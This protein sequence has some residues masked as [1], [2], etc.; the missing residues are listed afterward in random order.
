VTPV[1][2]YVWH[3]D[4]HRQTGERLYFVRLYFEPVYPN[5]VAELE[6]R[7]RDLN[8]FSAHVYELVGAYDLVLRI[9]YSGDVRQ[10]ITDLKLPEMRR[11]DFMEVRH[12]HEHWVMS[13]KR[14]SLDATPQI[15]D[16]SPEL[17]EE[18]NRKVNSDES[19][20]LDEYVEA[21]LIAPV[22]AGRGVKFFVSVVASFGT[23]SSIRFDHVL[24]SHVS[25]VLD[26]AS[27]LI[28]ARSVYAGDGFARLLLMGRFEPQDYFRFMERVVAE[29]N[30][31]YMRELFN[32]R[33]FTAFG[34]K[35]GP[36]LGTDAIDL[37]GFRTKPG[38]SRSNGATLQ[39]VGLDDLLRVGEGQHVEVKASAFLDINRYVHDATPNW[40]GL[41][42]EL[43][44]AVCGLLNQLDGRSSTL[45]IGAVETERYKKW[46][47]E[48][49]EKL[50]EVGVFT[51]LGIEEDNPSGDWDKY[52]RRLT[53]ALEAA[54]SP[55]PVP[56][57]TIILEEYGRES[58][59]KLLRIELLPAHKAFYQT[60]EDTLWVRQG[61]QTKV[62]RGGDR[63]DF[64]A[65]LRRENQN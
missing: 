23:S 43:V 33:T 3:P 35:E 7:L 51:V 27:D 24:F 63:E 50:A 48:R 57:M 64:V 60:D 1:T 37:S 21:G 8:V 42:P 16:L 65:E 34:V 41:R 59:K 38:P 17:I 6:D 5:V 10:L 47:D 40:S 62:L 58:G 36:L 9:W 39:S 28:Q 31:E 30:N 13:E 18:I 25:D 4:L 14:H 52:Q 53:D 19:H 49:P 22:P 20:D 29:L 55:S 32:A 56:Y 2:Q 26:R 54:I 45:V 15:S 11:A 12:I 44:K 46:L 61:A